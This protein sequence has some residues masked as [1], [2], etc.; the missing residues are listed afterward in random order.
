MRLIWHI[1]RTLC[2]IIVSILLCA[3]VVGVGLYAILFFPE[4]P[5]ATYA[6]PDA[7]YLQVRMFTA[8]QGNLP[9][10]YTHDV[11]LYLFDS[12]KAV[13]ARYTLIGRSPFVD[14]L[15]VTWLD[16]SN[17]S[18][19]TDQTTPFSMVATEVDGVRIHFHQVAETPPG[20]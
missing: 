14:S 9:P 8:G 12:H 19:T 5:A 6:V 11:K 18:V 15:N 20:L 17:L 2:V 10:D 7:P 3:G 16:R 13:W 4:K 1:Y